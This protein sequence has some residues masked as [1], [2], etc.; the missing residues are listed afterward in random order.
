MNLPSLELAEAVANSF[1]R[2]LIQLNVM[3]TNITVLCPDVI[4]IATIVVPDVA[5]ENQVI[6]NHPPAISS[7]LIPHTA[8]HNDA[9]RI[10]E[11]PLEHL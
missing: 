4:F 7:I 10:V 6:N 9:I 2:E 1:L 5:M 8:T 3:C 11:G